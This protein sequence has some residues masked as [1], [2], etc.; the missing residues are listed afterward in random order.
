MVDFAVIYRGGLRMV[1]IPSGAWRPGGRV[2]DPKNSVFGGFRAVFLNGGGDGSGSARCVL[3]RSIVFS[4]SQPVLPAGV[5]PDSDWARVCGTANSGRG[6]RVD[7]RGQGRINRDVPCDNADRSCGGPGSGRDRTH[8][9]PLAP[10]AMPRPR[11]ITPS[12]VRDGTGFAGS[13]F[14]SGLRPRSFYRRDRHH[15]VP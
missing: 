4:G 1:R 7:P 6:T 14:G 13:A 3:I 11:L 10:I 12:T 5:V 15:S 9:G 2:L 8:V